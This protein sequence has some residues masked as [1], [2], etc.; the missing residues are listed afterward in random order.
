MPDRKEEMLTYNFESIKTP[1][2]EHIYKC[3]KS[4]IIN[5][6]LK[7]GDRLPS[8]RAFA[9]NNGVS[10]ITIE[11][12]YEQLIS[13]GYIF[14]LPRKGYYVS[15]VQIVK[16]DKDRDEG[17]H[18]IE[19][20]ETARVYD[21]DLSGNYMPPSSFPFSVWAK[22]MRETLSQ[23]RELLMT[24]SPTG[25]TLKLRTAIANHLRSF[26]GMI[27]SSD[28]IIVGAGTEY[29]YVLLIQLI[30][31]DKIFCIE[32]P[33]YYKIAKI[34]D[35]HSIN[36]EY[37]DMDEHGI[38]VPGI[39]K[40]GADI[41]HISTAHH[42]PTGITM[43]ASRRYE[44]IAWANER[45]GRYII[46]DDYDSEFRPSGK[47]IPPLFDIDDS[48]KTIYV[49]TF[50]KSLASTM[51][52]SYMVLPAHLI[53]KFYK[54][55]SFYSCTVSVFEQYTL[56]KFIERGYF[57]KHINRKRIHYSKQREKVLSAIARSSLS[58]KCQVVENDSG[59]HFLLK[60]DTDLSDKKIIEELHEKSINISA[61]SQFYA[62]EKEED[63]H[64]FLFNYSN[65]DD[66][67]LD[68]TLEVI[69]DI[70][71]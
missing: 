1:L 32:N 61:L 68:S 23:D 13:E 50:S 40:S 37:A 43:P 3:I 20:P 21:V 26:H 24:P 18:E 35:K 19:I 5:G 33:G 16:S 22:L 71:S 42:F 47:P 57:E 6:V 55:L 29:L 56:A 12:A 8:K 11:N 31:N 65:I 44:I 38:M 14:S 17:T 48:E 7:K 9:K 2:Y 51:R 70:I 45:E 49:N 39:E 28:Q 36:Y 15:D 69:S 10:T 41:A 58:D 60:L 62:K 34:Y 64:T 52:I 66:S 59:L 27:T 67:K 30:G 54:E 4:D 46:E 25:G 63:K 53:N